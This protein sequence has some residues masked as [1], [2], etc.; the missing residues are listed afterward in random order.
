M[1]NEVDDELVHAKWG[2]AWIC[3]Q[4]VMLKQF[5][6]LGVHVLLLGNLRRTHGREIQ[7]WAHV[8]PSAVS[9]TNKYTPGPGAVHVW[10]PEPS[11]TTGPL[12]TR[13]VHHKDGGHCEYTPMALEPSGIGKQ[14]GGITLARHII[15]MGDHLLPRLSTGRIINEPSISRWQPRRGRGIGPPQ[16]VEVGVRGFVEADVDALSPC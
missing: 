13:H 8:L 5:L 7:R 16:V 15:H 3:D 12:H 2:L 9:P 1:R 10:R 14:D 11:W 4:A 6:R